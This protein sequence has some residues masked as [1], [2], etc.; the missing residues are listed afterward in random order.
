MKGIT[1]CVVAVLLFAL[2]AAAQDYRG[3]IQGSIT[4]ETRAVMPG[5]SVTLRNDATGV[6]NMF[7]ADEL[8][9]YI[10]DFVD[11]G[12]YTVTAEL[13]GFAKQEQKNIR[14]QQRGT[15]TLDF[16]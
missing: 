2:P 6:A 4:D 16:L 10:F 1:F 15:V 12:I 11:P 14:V 7:V 9:R 13:P 3:R 8:G 5:V